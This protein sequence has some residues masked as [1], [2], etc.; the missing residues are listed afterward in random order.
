LTNLYPK[1]GSGIRTIRLTNYQLA[2]SRFRRR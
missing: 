2:L 1:I